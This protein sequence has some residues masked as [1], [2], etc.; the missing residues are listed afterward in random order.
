MLK[1]API[2]G[3]NMVLQRNRENYIWGEGTD[4]DAV[5]IEFLRH[6]YIADVVEGKWKIKLAAVDAGG[7]YTMDIICKE[8]KIHFQNILIGEVWFAGGQSNMEL[9]LKDS[10]NG[11]AL[12]AQTDKE[13]VRFFNVPKLSYIDENFEKEYEKA[14]WQTMKG[15]ACDT[16]SAVAFHFANEIYESLRVPVGIIDCY[17]GGT[18][19]LCWMSEEMVRREPAA[20]ATF[21]DFQKQI[22]S[23]SDEEYE[24]EL[25]AFN[26]SVKAWDA[27]AD[28]LRKVNPDIQWSELCEK[29]GNNPWEPPMGKKSPYRPCGLHETMVKQ[30]APYGIRGFIFYQGESDDVRS[31]FYGKLNS[32]LIKQWRQDFEDEDLDFYLTQ[33]PMYIADGAED[34]QNWCII[35]EQQKQ[36]TKINKRTHMAV[37]IDCGEYDNIHPTDKSIP[38]QRLALQVLGKT[39]GRIKE[40]DAMGIE[41]VEYQNGKMVIHFH[42]TYGGIHLWRNADKMT[43]DNKTLV[44][45]KERREK[46]EKF[47]GFEI[48]GDGEHYVE[49]QGEIISD[50][51]VALWSPEVENPIHVRYAWSNFCVTNI[52]NNAD[53]PLVPFSI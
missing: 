24:A 2:F 53:L 42:S 9:A 31:R 30:V 47:Y 21:M 49:A 33:L 5:E 25:A 40:Y 19:A 52:Y 26:E 13:A 17:W 36:V 37:I 15:S 38:G 16:M 1:V 27:K 41:N 51:A 11:K 14:G 10:Y 44:G 4:G 39:Y 8:E 43:E 50:E 45:W 48:S 7:P 12:A 22:E 23:R 28:E 46:P 6:T 18:S 34:D 3:D 20:F 32:M 35:R 29:L